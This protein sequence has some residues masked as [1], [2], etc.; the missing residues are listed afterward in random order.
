[1][2]DCWER[3]L[4]GGDL[5][6]VSCGQLLCPV[7]TAGLVIYLM[8]IYNWK[9]DAVRHYQVNDYRLSLSISFT[10]F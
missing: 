9:H 3:L 8:D 5:F 1:M 6:T 4:V 2:R 10:R 7:D